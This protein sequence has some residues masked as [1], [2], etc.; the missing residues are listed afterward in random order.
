M[1]KGMVDN[2]D[3]ATL[4]S[5]DHTEQGFLAAVDVDVVSKPKQLSIKV[6]KIISLSKF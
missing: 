2:K 4:S 6:S 3:D 5:V 1:Q